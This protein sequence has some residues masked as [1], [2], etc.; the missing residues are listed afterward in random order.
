MRIRWLCQKKSNEMEIKATTLVILA[1][2][3]KRSTRLRL[4]PTERLILLAT[5]SYESQIWLPVFVKKNATT[6]PKNGS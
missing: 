2:N 6:G 1:M 3:E 5:R 4:E